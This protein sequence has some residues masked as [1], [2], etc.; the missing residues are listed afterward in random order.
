M[1]ALTASGARGYICAR[2]VV[3]LLIHGSC[4]VRG[5]R[6][7]SEGR[8]G[9]ACGTKPPDGPL[10]ACGTPYQRCGCAVL[11]SHRR[12]SRLIDGV[13]AYPTGFS[14]LTGFYWNSA[15]HCGAVETT[16]FR[17][18]VAFLTGS[19]WMASILPILRERHAWVK[20]L[21]A[22]RAEAKSCRWT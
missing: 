14:S 4:E 6:K 17:Q 20:N 8:L 21:R 19:W 10:I 1:Q 18:R 9:R 7:A 15:L 3:V 11:P 16:A 13:D 12:T 2:G 22:V 5:S